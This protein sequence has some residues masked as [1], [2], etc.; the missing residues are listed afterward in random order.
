MKVDA[1]SEILLARKPRRDADE[2][3]AAI[4]PR[5]VSGKARPA[6][7][8]AGR[9]TGATTK[10]DDRVGVIDPHRIE[11]LIQHPHENRLPATHLKT[12]DDRV[13]DGILQLIGHTIG[14]DAR[15]LGSP[16]FQTRPIDRLSDACKALGA[17]RWIAIRPTPFS[18]RP[19]KGTDMKRIVI[20]ENVS[21]LVFRTCPARS[22]LTDEELGSFDFQACS[23]AASATARVSEIETRLSTPVKARSRLGKPSRGATIRMECWGC[24][25]ACSAP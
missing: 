23:T 7:Y 1:A 5:D 6:G 21:P 4:D 20:S 12:R 16:S 3:W 10:I 9:D 15:R 22:V 13:K 25:S 11:I 14:V 2:N 18:R 24:S 19:T 8:P 17:I